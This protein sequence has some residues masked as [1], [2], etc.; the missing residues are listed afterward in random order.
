M[1]VTTDEKRFL[2]NPLCLSKKEE[3]KTIGHGISHNGSL[4][5]L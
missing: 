2:V 3:A 1:E 5:C 4:F